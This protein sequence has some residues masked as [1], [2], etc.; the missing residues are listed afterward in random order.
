M[1]FIIYRNN[2]IIDL[3][4]KARQF[5]IVYLLKLISLGITKKSNRCKQ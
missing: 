2:Q 1:K 4:L 3:K 5:M